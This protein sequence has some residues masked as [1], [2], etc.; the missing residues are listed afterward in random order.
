MAENFYFGWLIY[1][2]ICITLL[3][4]IGR[5]TKKTQFQLITIIYVGLGF[6]LAVFGNSIS[7]D[8]IEYKKIIT[9]VAATKEPFTHI[10][11]SYIYLIHKIGNSFLLYRVIIYA[12]QFVF[13]YF[14]I[15]LS[16]NRSR[17]ILSFLTLFSIICLYDCIGG[18]AYLCYTCVLLG[19]IVFRCVSKILGIILLVCGI[20]LHKMGFILSPLLLAVS[21]I[22]V[23]FNRKRL[24]IYLIIISL[25]TIIL[26]YIIQTRFGELLEQVGSINSDGAQ[27]LSQE[28][29]ANAGG[30]IWWTLI[31]I[32][33]KY[34]I[35]SVFL[36]SAYKINGLKTVDSV[37]LMNFRICICTFTIANVY[38]C[39]GLPDGTIGGR[40]A[41][42]G[43]IPLCFLWSR[44]SAY[45][46]ISS[47]VK[48]IIIVGAFLYLMMTNAYIVGVSHI[49]KI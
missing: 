3:L 48:N 25:I 15:D 37:T 16:I 17:Y 32:Y 11:D 46:N 33:K 49:N 27:Y 34:F 41:A 13:L 39:L 9:E 35:L 26:R 2:V 14:I 43:Y 5:K 8:F 31:S 24:Y 4:N 29:G 12:L 42:A 38:S 28:E 23:H 6:I 45:H 1:N 30:S 18:R 22:P 36:Y 21:Y 47:K 19:I 7:P 40:F 44:L 20:Y 10:E